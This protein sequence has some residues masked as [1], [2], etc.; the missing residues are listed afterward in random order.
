M[1][2]K[3]GLL[4]GTFDPVHMGHLNLAMELKEKR[5]LDEVWFVPAQINPHK[6]LVL[7]A[8]AEHRLEMVK[9]AIQDFPHF[10]VKD[11]ELKRAPPSYTV[12]TISTLVKLDKEKQLQFFWLMGEDV[13]PEFSRWSQPEI[14]IKMATLLIGSR[15]TDK[16]FDRLFDN[17]EI[18]EAIHQGW[19]K[20][21]LMDISS[22]ELRQRLFQGLFC[23]H[24]LSAPVLQYIN[25][26]QLYGVLPFFTHDPT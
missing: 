15:L 16:P 22:T 1:K 7:P 10:F 8:S 21:R 17:L 3:I 4:G 12:E 6:T 19:T 5:E 26:N 11:L 13:L 25:Q 2:K 9:L 14:I 20:T 24:L 23:G 18:E